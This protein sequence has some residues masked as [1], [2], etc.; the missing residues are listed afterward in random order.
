MA[1]FV[2]T[3]NGS[4]DLSL[5]EDIYRYLGVEV[6]K[7]HGASSEEFSLLEKLYSIEKEKIDLELEVL[8]LICWIKLDMIEMQRDGH[9]VSHL[10]DG[11]KRV[12]RLINGK[13]P[14]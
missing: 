8:N 9:T 12:M 6:L 7:K 3:D 13:N 11:V 1:K 14:I 5:N 2:I 4:Y 10:E